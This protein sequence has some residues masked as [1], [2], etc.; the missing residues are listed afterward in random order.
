LREL[1]IIPEEPNARA[2]ADYLLTQ[3]IVTKVV[4][5]RDGRF[6]VWVQNEDRLDEARQAYGE[7]VRDPDDVRFQAATRSAR[8]IRKRAE[9]V[10]AE[11][12]RRS[13]NLRDRWEGPLYRRAPLTV[14]L[15]V[16]SIAAFV[17]EKFDPTLFSRLMFSLRFVTDDGFVID[18][19]FANIARGEVWRLITPIFIHLSVYHIFFN[20][21]A[22][23]A[24]G[25]R[26]E[27]VKGRTRFLILVLVTAV[28][29]NTGQFLVS[30]G[31][32]GGMSGVVFALAAYL[33]IKGQVAPDEG[34]GLDRQNAQL[35][36]AWFLL[37]IFG[38]VLFPDGQG[39]PFNMANMA[40]GVGLLAGLVFGLLRF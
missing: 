40:H 38:P 25:Q 2:L 36:F 35:M 15:I 29:S 1:G 21:L 37:G 10:E 19:G 6:A 34:L 16:A 22:L 31:G 14:A 30:G 39:F 13:H 17:G 26:I 9:E 32:F 33:W 18:R 3:N 8:E 27:M 23:A 5:N 7:F 4:A 24:F 20:M 28:A 11:H 12:R